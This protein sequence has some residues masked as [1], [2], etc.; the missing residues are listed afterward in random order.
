MSGPNDHPAS[1]PLFA[2]PIPEAPAEG[3]QPPAV[4]E[5]LAADATVD[6]AAERAAAGVDEIIEALDRD[7]VGLRPVKT[8]VAVR[9]VGGGAQPAYVL[10][11]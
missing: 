10:H 11:R 7:L 9:V 5:P 4:P 6:L 8:K 3:D 2:L 1:R